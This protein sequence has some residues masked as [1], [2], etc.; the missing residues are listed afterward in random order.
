MYSMMEDNS[1][2][3]RSTKFKKLTKAICGLVSEAL[4]LIL[5]LVLSRKLDFFSLE[6]LCL[7]VQIDDYSMVRFLPFDRTDEEGINIVLQKSMDQN[8]KP[9]HLK[10]PKN[11]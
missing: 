1:D 9:E 2:T 4:N 7:C 5:H 10:I 6:F 8:I 3:I 11:L